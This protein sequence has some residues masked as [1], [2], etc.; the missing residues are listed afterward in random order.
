MTLAGLLIACTT[1]STAAPRAPTPREQAAAQLLALAKLE[2]LDHDRIAAV[3]GT[4]IDGAAT[5]TPYRTDR[6]LP[7]TPLFSGIELAEAGDW[8]ALTLT[9]AASLELTLQDLEPHLLDA[10]YAMD[11]QT[12]HHSNGFGIDGVLHHFAVNR[13]EL[14]VDIAYASHAATMRAAGTAAFGDGIDQVSDRA[15]RDLVRSITV[16]SKQRVPAEAPTLRK[17]QRWAVEHP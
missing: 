15:R 11:V 9:P 8:R 2:R 14:V 5:V 1:A 3:L 13:N 6:S 10:R 12:V 7:P 16:T 17:F 4:K